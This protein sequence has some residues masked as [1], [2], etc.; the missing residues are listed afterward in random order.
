MK[1]SDGTM[2]GARWRCLAGTARH[3][4]GIAAYDP[5]SAACLL[6]DGEIVAI[7]REERFSRRGRDASFPTRAIDHCL[8]EGGIEVEDLDYVGLHGKPLL[9]LERMLEEACVRAAPGRFRSI[10]RIVSL[11]TGDAIF[12]ERDIRRE[13]GYGGEI[14]YAERH[15]S[16]AA[17]AFFTS[18]FERAA[19]VTMDGEQEGASIGVGRGNELALIRELRWPV[20]P[21]R[22]HAIVARYVGFGMDA[23]EDERVRPGSGGEPR[24]VDL[25]LRELVDL[26]DDGSF[27]LNREPPDPGPGACRRS[28]GPHRL[29]GARGA[30]PGSTITR[31]E[32][33]LACSVRAV[34][35]MILTRVTRHA[36]RVTGMTDA[37]FAGDVVHE[38]V[39]AFRT[40]WTAPFD[41]V[42]TAPVAGRAGGALGIAQLVWHR[43]CGKPRRQTGVSHLPAEP[44]APASRSETA[45]PDPPARRLASRVALTL[46]A[47]LLHVLVITPSWFL[48][49]LLGRGPPGRRSERRWI[50]RAGE[51]SPTDMERRF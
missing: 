40:R 32:R 38:H 8:S 10:E 7:A 46:V 41:R 24:Y 33:D 45:S 39:R 13:L 31:R 9:R 15:E 14:L 2:S 36:R 4:L 11:W 18:P 43:H 27:A 28:E 17:S 12:A 47:V 25:I 42:S 44:R 1:E 34:R 37:C 29:A 16:L 6:R 50:S 23:R 35:E 48:R 51:P 3:V 30:C 21:G 19:I 5:G 22:L 26:R 20:A 49:R